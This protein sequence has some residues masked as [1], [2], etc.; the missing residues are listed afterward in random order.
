MTQK[1]QYY[2]PDLAKALGVGHIHHVYVAEVDNQ[3]VLRIE[4]DEA[5]KQEEYKT[6]RVQRKPK[7]EKQSRKDPENQHAPITFGEKLA[8]GAKD[9]FLNPERN[10]GKNFGG[11]GFG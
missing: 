5:P 6:V 3:T 9:F 8:A 2:L 10:K 4:C 11:R 7:Q 1:L